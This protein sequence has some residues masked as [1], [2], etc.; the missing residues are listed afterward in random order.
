MDPDMA[1]GA[2]D[3]GFAGKVTPRYRNLDEMTG[4]TYDDLLNADHLGALPDQQ[5]T[6]FG[7][8]NG[9]ADEAMGPLDLLGASHRCI[10]PVRRLSGVQPDPIRHLKC[11]SF[12]H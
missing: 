11:T 8:R 1:P 7:A 6:R 9:Q 2:L 4:K 3:L 10:S 12:T 5:S